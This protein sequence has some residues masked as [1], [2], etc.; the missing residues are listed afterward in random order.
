MVRGVGGDARANIE[1]F[2]FRAY[3]AEHTQW[4]TIGRSE[5]FSYT[6]EGWWPGEDGFKARV[7]WATYAQ[8]KRETRTCLEEVEA[9]RDLWRYLDRR[10]ASA[11]PH[12]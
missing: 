2:D 3:Q 11:R 4:R 8:R 1:E 12:D 6:V 5:R 9:I 10:S 7:D